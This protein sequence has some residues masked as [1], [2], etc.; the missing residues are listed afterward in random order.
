MKH[1]EAEIKE[2]GRDHLL[3]P[4]LHCEEKTV[5]QLVDF[6]GLNLKDV[7]HYTLYEIKDGARTKLI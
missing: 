1:Y 3:K 5:E 6:W 4:S 7:E 2:I